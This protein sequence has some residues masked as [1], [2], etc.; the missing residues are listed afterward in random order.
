M[1]PR[2]LRADL[3]SGFLVFLIALPLC[4]GISLAGGV[5]AISG[6]LTA[7]VG[8]LVASFL[9]SSR[10][11]IKGPPAGLIVIVLGAATELSDDPMVAYHRLLAVSVVAGILQII[12]ALLKAGTLGDLMPSSVI[13]GMLAAIGVIIIS[14]QVHV[15]MGVTPAASKPFGLLAEIPHSLLHPNPAVFIIGGLSLIMLFGLPLLKI[16]WLKKV[17]A[18]MLVLL[19]AVPLGLYFKLGTE[20]SYEMFGGS[21]TLGPKYLIQLPGSLLS[22]LAFP[23]FSVVFTP[24]SI[25]YII[26]FLLVGSIE[27]LLTVSAV[28]TIDPEKQT[29]DIN[30]DFLCTGIANTVAAFIGGTPMIS[31]IVRT[32]A[33]IDNGAKSAWANFFHG[34]FLLLSLALIPGVI[35]MIPQAALAAMLIYTGYRL[36][37]PKEFAHAYHVGIEQL[38][39]F[40]VTLIV[41]VWTDL[42]TGVATGLVCKILLHLKNGAP[43]KAMF[44]AI[45]KEQQS[46][47]RLTLTVHESAIFTNFLAIKTRLQS[48]GPDVKEVVINFDNAWVV[49]HTV[50]DKLDRFASK[51][52]GE[53]KLILTGLGDHTASSEHALAARRKKPGQLATQVQ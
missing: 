35:Q 24:V 45:V 22:S 16:G 6:V 29:S 44:K 13:H 36:A 48:L 15:A 8:G 1:K 46:D 9:G 26:M 42:L 4:L 53:R 3:I 39:L 50:L 28:D 10:L 43:V 20:H 25:K 12:L 23:D 7:I 30:K 18:P 5:P 33:N 11:T 17:P 21:Y 34:A 47:G 49:D 38:F 52:E 37:A 2:N 32:R 27:S 14:K 51:W 40:S 19:M 41:T 31:E